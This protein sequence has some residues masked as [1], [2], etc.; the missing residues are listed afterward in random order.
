[1]F[2]K[3]D[4]SSCSKSPIKMS[5]TNEKVL[6]STEVVKGANEITVS[7]MVQ[8]LLL[9]ATSDEANQHKYTNRNF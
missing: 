9:K 3:S 7:K 1:M 8:W 2:K 6:Y 4:Q 5:I